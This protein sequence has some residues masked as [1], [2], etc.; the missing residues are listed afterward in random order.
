[1]RSA[2]AVVIQH[3]MVR[4]LPGPHLFEQAVRLGAAIGG[5]LL[6][7]AGMA[8]ILGVDAFGDAVE[9]A[10]ARVRKLLAK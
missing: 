2:A 9:M 6:A 10:G 4:G 1:V 7:L 5:G 8:N 3:T